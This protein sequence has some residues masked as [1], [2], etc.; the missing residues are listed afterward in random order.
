MVT[1]H[2][3]AIAEL[4]KQQVQVMWSDAECQ[5]HA[6]EPEE[7]PRG[8][9]IN[10]ILRSEMF[11]LKTTLDDIT[12]KKLDSRNKLASKEKLSEKRIQHEPGKPAE[13]ELEYL[14]RLNNELSDLGFNLSSDDPDFMDY[15]REKYHTK[16]S[17]VI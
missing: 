11:G 2:P 8:M 17:E 16:P 5:V 10:L 6:N 13:T 12:Q 14:A 4:E 7:S 1:H 15:L 9:G 3:L